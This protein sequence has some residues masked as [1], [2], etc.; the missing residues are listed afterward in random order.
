M[1]DNGQ[2]KLWSQLTFA[3][4]C[5]APARRVMSLRDPV[6]KMSKSEED[7]RSTI[8]L[9]DTV[10]DVQK[11]IKQAV[12]DSEPGIS[13]DPVRRP[14]ISNLIEIMSHLE[15]PNGRSCE[16]IAS[17]FQSTRIKAFKDHVETTINAHIQPIRER[18]LEIVSK[19]ERENSYL[20]DIA[21]QGAA[22]AR[23]SANRTMKAVRDAMGL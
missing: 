12:T 23:E 20:Q 13:Y 18:F 8:L 1:D 6:H 11:K 17:E 9:N 3:I 5:T 4:L 14:G 19:D 15:E 22:R 16:E 21:A 7:K 2:W 10:K